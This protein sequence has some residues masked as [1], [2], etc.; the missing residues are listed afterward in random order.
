MRSVGNKSA[1]VAARLGRG[2]GVGVFLTGPLSRPSAIP[3]C[4]HH[5]S[6]CDEGACGANL[7][8]HRSPLPFY[9]LTFGTKSSLVSIF[10]VL[11]V[12]IESHCPAF[13]IHWFDPIGIEWSGW[14]SSSREPKNTCTPTWRRANASGIRRQV[15]QC[16]SIF[17]TFVHQKR[18]NQVFRVAR[19]W[20]VL[21]GQLPHHTLL[22]LFQSLLLLMLLSFFLRVYRMRRKRTT[23]NQWWELF[24][25]KTSRF[26][27]YNAATQR[28]VWHRPPNCDIIPLAK[29]QVTPI[30]RF[31][32]F[33]H[34]FVSDIFP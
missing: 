27:Y 25:H 18:D 11:H 23:D 1:D 7:E 33:S 12:P 15:F 19:F 22:T 9:F 6:G 32:S 30:F 8:T 13:E 20:V 2:D 34:S 29:L 3:S 14:R 24:D 26:Y 17:T 4:S 5:Q 31:I 10:M 16:K 28:T 21:V